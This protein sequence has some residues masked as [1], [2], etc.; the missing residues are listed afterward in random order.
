MLF[1]RRTMQLAACVSLA[2]IPTLAQ[3]VTATNLFLLPNSSATSPI[4]SAFR[5]DPFSIISSFTAQPGASFVHVHPN[6][7]KVYVIARSGADTLLVLDAN[8]PSNVLKRITLGQAEAAALSPDG[9]RLVVAAGSVHLI[10]TSADNVL[11]TLSDLGGTPTDVAIALDGSRAFVLSPGANRLTAV[12][13]NTGQLAGSA[14]S[15]SGNASSVTVGPDGLVYVTAQNLIQILDGRS[16]T[17]VREI[18]LNAQPT[19]P[20]FTPDG[21]YAILTNRTPVTGSSVIQIDLATYNISTIPNFQVI[22]DRVQFVSGNRAYAISNQT[23]RLYEVTVN[24][25]NIN[26]PSFSG[27]AELTNVT[28]FAIS[29]EVPSARFMFVVTGGTMHRIDMNGNPGIGAGQVAIPSAP[30]PLTYSAPQTTGSPVVILPYNNAQTTTPGGT[31][32]PLIARVTDSFGRP[33]YAVNVTFTSDN[34]NAQ[35][36]GAQA[37]TNVLGYAQTTVIAP[38][39]AGTFNV[40]ASAGPGPSAPTATYVL[41][42]STGS[43]GGGGGSAT[44]LMSI[45]GGNGQLVVANFLL[46]NPMTVRVRDNNGKP[47]VGQAITFSIT[48]GSGTMQTATA[49]GIAIPNTTCSGNVCTAIT[50][51]KG[52]AAASF[53]AA[54]VPP[55]FSWS[56]QQIS[57]SNGQATVNFIITTL[58][59]GGV[60]GG[61]PIPPNVERIKPLDNTVV[62]QAGTTVAEAI[63]VRVVASS[64]LQAGQPI[65][66]VALTAATEFTDPLLGPTASCA[67]EGDLALTDS[68]GIATCNLKVGGRLG[69]TVLSANVGSALSLGGSRIILDVRAGPP[70]AVTQVLGN[71]QSGNPGARLP[72]VFGAQILDAFGNVLTGQAVTWEVVTPNS[73]TLSNI[74]SVSD[75]NGRVSALGTLGSIAG[76]NQVRL[77]VGNATLQ[78]FNFTVNLTISALNKVSG[79]AQS[80]LINSSFAAPLVVEVRDERGNPVPNQNVQWSIVSGAGTLSANAVATAANGQ[81]SVTVRAGS[82]T[83]T[84]TVQARLG[85]FTQSFTLTARPP[86]PVVS[87][88]GIVTTARNQAGITPCGLATIFGS[89]LAFGVNGVVNLNFLGIGALPTSY[90]GLEILIGG[91][92]APIFAVSNQNGQESVMI[93]VPCEIS[94]PGT[95]SIAIRIPGAVGTV[96]GVQVFRAAP[97]IFETTAT[98]STRAYAAIIRPDGSYITPTNPGRRGEVVYAAVTGLGTVSPA[99]ATNR[100]GTGGQLVG[101]NLIVGVNNQG[102]RIVSASYATGMIGIYWIGFEIPNDATPGT[103]INFSIAAESPT[104]QLVFSNPSTIAAIQ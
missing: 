64:G 88:S 25:F 13:L 23:Q 33:L 94:A 73:I 95:T 44:G 50:D 55:G 87:A 61:T 16:M 20:T 40:T 9:R 84:I 62:A 22:L 15:V 43:T 18:Q 59:S 93:Q 60:V 65:P 67:G 26:P 45:V 77:R 21:R 35:I 39:N 54:L 74:V 19:R 51:E 56:P 11:S 71:N 3:S 104:G 90:N 58:E 102:V 29:N 10:D 17:I 42:S 91:I 52:E 53:L 41:T 83:G 80:A 98:S 31:Y 81:S 101:A 48:S 68:Q 7:Q 96:E 8:N 75:F 49:N 28:D 36:L 63:V 69:Q 92:S 78:V 89:N 34:P 6:G 85:N 46:T 1:L 57:A 79:D 5:T 2:A 37:T 66:N 4:V 24:P 30:G 47:I 76:T 99:T 38:A 100:V 82:T 103:F 14:F 12:D 86:G 70:A 97:G 32:R 27:I 72:L